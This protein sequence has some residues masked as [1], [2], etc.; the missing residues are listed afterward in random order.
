MTAAATRSPSATR[1]NGIARH[2]NLPRPTSVETLRHEIDRV[3]ENFGASSSRHPFD[4]PSFEPELLAPRTLLPNSFPAV[5]IVERLKSYRITA[6]LPGLN[7]TD[8]EVEL[9]NGILTAAS[10]IHAVSAPDG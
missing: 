6:E 4:S 2:R 8:I 3:F 7:G 5:D 9:S 10:R 1:N